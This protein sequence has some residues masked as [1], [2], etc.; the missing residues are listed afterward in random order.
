MDINEAKS[1][2]AE[3]R[4]EQ[5]IVLKAEMVELLSDLEGH[6]LK[7]ECTDPGDQNI[8]FNVAGFI[9]RSISKNLTCQDYKDFYNASDEAPALTFVEDEN[10]YSIKQDAVT[11]ATFLKQVNRGGLCTLVEM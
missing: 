3:A 8:I 6:E 4:E 9:A 11:R 7:V 10:G 5:E 1:T 2:M